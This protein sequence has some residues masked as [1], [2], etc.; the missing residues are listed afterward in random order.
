MQHILR[1]VGTMW[2]SLLAVKANWPIPVVHSLIHVQGYT[3]SI[4]SHDF[5]WLCFRHPITLSL[6]PIY[7]N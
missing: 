3:T 6:Q 2:L 7:R 5:V 1:W 4:Q